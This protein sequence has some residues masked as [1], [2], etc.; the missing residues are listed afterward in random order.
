MELYFN[1]PRFKM[2]AREW[3]G[4]LETIAGQTD[5]TLKE[6]TFIQP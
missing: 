2:Q 1:A 6:C 4:K 3:N 5:I